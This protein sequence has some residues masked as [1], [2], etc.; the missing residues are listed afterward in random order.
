L[1]RS[2]VSRSRM[3]LRWSRWCAIHANRWQKSVACHAKQVPT[4]L[5]TNKTVYVNK[6]GVYCP[7][8]REAE[9]FSLFR[10]IL[11]QFQKSR[12]IISMRNGAGYA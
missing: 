12:N 9:V 2:G 4:V 5:A 1:R 8:W 7:R 3:R 10:S 6:T 11:Q